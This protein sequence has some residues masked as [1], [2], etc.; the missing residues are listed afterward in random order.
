MNQGGGKK[1]ER[2]KRLFGKEEAA[3]KLAQINGAE[4]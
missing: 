1:K 4:M 3:P 2:K